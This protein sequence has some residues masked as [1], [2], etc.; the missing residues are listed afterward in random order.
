[1]A[2]ESAA[3]PPACGADAGGARLRDLHLGVH[4]QA[5][6]GGRARTG[7]CCAWLRGGCSYVRSPPRTRVLQLAPLRLRASTFEIWGALANGARLVLLPTPGRRSLA[8]LARVAGARRQVTH[9][10][11]DGGAVPPDGRRA[12]G[13]ACGGSTAGGRRRRQSAGAGAAGCWR[14]LRAAAGQRVRADREHDV[15]RT[16]APVDGGRRRADTVPIGR[17]IANTRRMCWTRTGEPVPVGVPG[18]LFLGGDGRGARLLGAAGADGGAVRARPVRAWAGRR[19]CT[20]RGDRVR[21]RA[22][23]ARWSFSAGST[24]R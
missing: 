16:L 9:A 6:G 17:P 15:L 18:E 22:G 4:G 12:A 23:R 5:Q 14:R 11:A 8:A 19:G 7:P 10:V 13:R 3:G 24:T 1:M 20:A 2:R 21:R